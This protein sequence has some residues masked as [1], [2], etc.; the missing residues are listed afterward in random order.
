MGCLRLSRRERDMRRPVPIRLTLLATLSATLVFAWVWIELNPAELMVPTASSNPPSTSLG[1]TEP[2]QFTMP[3]T[4]AFAEIAARPVFNPSRRPIPPPVAPTAAPVAQPAPPPPP[5]PPP[6]N[7]TL[8]GIMAGLEDRFALVR[9]GGAPTINT[10][11]EG[12]DIGGWRVYLI[13]PDRILLRTDRKSKR[14]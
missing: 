14:L 3:P 11:F 8:V 1:N 13:L 9:L 7:L 12:Q 6:I 2:L 5:P 10:I 4:A